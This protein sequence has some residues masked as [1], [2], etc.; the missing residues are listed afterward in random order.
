MRKIDNLNSELTKCCETLVEC[1]AELKELGIPKEEH[2]IYKIG[3]AI[4]EINEVRSDIYKINPDLKPELWDEPP[5]E[6]HF[7]EWF[8]EAKNVAE[9]YIR[10]G[11]PDKAI[12]TFESF[13]FIG[14][15]ESVVAKAREAI[16][17]VKKE[18]GV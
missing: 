3:K 18:Y 2:A 17:R 11:K 5:T 15:S 14:P 1:A 7:A 4:A 10:D 13:I 8:N 9:E 16:E 12:E 6:Q